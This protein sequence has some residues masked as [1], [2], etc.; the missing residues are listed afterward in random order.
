MQQQVLLC[1]VLT[2]S[3][4]FYWAIPGK[5]AWRVSPICPKSETICLCMQRRIAHSSHNKPCIQ[6][7]TF[8]CHHPSQHCPFSSSYR[9]LSARPQGEVLFPSLARV[10]ML[11]GSSRVHDSLC[12]DVSGTKCLKQP[13]QRLHLQEPEQS[14]V[15]MVSFAQGSCGVF[16][17]AGA[18]MSFGPAGW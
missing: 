4:D 14:F 1:E 6:M 11:A 13:W 17:G 10:E 2:V 18:G 16:R 5:T 12:S 15:I 9:S 3:E 8:A 7:K